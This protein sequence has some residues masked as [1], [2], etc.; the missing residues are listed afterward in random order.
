MLKITEDVPHGCLIAEP[1]GALTAADFADF[2]RRFDEWV[3]GGRPAPNI[4]IHAAAFPGWADFGAFIAH[5]K[6][7]RDHQ[8]RVEKIALVSDAGILAIGP[9]I[10]GIFVA[11]SIRHFPADRMDEALAWVAERDE[12][13]TRVTVIE[14]LPDRAVGFSVEGVVTARDYAEVIR[15]LVEKKLETHAKIDLLY[16]IAPGF[17]RFS[18]GAMWH[19]ASL[20]LQHLTD[21]RRVAVVTDVEW[22]ARAT[23]LFA[24]LMPAEVQVFPDRDL[25]EAKA[26]LASEP[27]PKVIPVPM[28]DG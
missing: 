10:A 2:A 25:A 11:A 16:R 24:P 13:G 1:S 12:P 27:N 20:G 5:M 26:W 15:P 22:I 7:I 14:G 3:A 17:E 4:V 19:D 28:E 9:S 18:A 21:F 6:F 8:R 23:R